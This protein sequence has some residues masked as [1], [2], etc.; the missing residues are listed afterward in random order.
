M[1][2]DAS[3]RGFAAFALTAGIVM[4]AGK[5]SASE[6][7]FWSMWNETEPQAAVLAKVGLVE[8]SAA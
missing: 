8:A 2:S 6:L 1:L 3:R 4:G 7:V 5:A